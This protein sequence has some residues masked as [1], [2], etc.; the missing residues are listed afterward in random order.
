VGPLFSVGEAVV[1]IDASDI[2]S[3]W[4]ALHTGCIYTIRSIE[5]TP[6]KFGII[7]HTIHKNASY[8][9]RLVGV[10][11]TIDFLHGKELGYAETHFEKISEG[12]LRKLQSVGV[13][14]EET[15]E[16]AA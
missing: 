16:M 11:N 1:C 3:R 8:I 13:H 5:P 12:A 6:T 7:N 2:P 10:Q 4:A 15:E 9:V 14:T